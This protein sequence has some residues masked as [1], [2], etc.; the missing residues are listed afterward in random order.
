MVDNVLQNNHTDDESVVDNEKAQS[1]N[2]DKL[3]RAILPKSLLFMKYALCSP[4]ICLVLKVAYILLSIFLVYIL[5]IVTYFSR[6]G[7]A[8]KTFYDIQG[9]LYLAT[10]FICAISF[11]KSLDND[12]LSHMLQ[13][14][15]SIDPKLPIKFAAVTHANLLVLFVSLTTFALMA[16]ELSAG[17]RAGAGITSIFYMTPYVLVYSWFVCLIYAQWIR[18]EDY[19]LNLRQLRSCN[20]ARYHSEKFPFLLSH[21][22]E[23]SEELE[24]PRSGT[25]ELSSSSITSFNDINVDTLTNY[26]ISKKYYEELTICLAFSKCCG[27]GLFFFSMFSI[28]MHVGVIWSLY[29]NIYRIEGVISFLIISLI[30]VLEIGFLLSSCNESGHLVCREICSLLLSESSSS[31]TESNSYREASYLLGCMDYA[32]LEITYFGNFSLRARTLLAILGSIF[33]AIIP[34]LVLRS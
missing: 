10:P 8:Y 5:F 6:D 23:I 12:F 2:K 18:L 7:I 16:S 22:L 11:L 34:G 20:E 33:A 1:V 3:Y 31:H 14:S 28:I 32:K 24:K 19:L 13:D 27:K 29:R 25:I 26:A 30:Q 21:N 9:L 15:L 4:T 17:D